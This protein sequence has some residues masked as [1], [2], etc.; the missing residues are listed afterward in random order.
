MK[1]GSRC[2][3]LGL[4]TLVL[5]GSDGST[6]FADPPTQEIKKTTDRVIEILQD[7]MSSGDTKKAER[8]EMLRQAL[9][10]RFDFREMARRSLGS[11][12]KSQNGRQEEF[13]SAFTNFVENAYVIKI[14][15]FKDEKII[16][17]RERVEK[18]FAE[19]DTKIVPSKGDPFS[20]N[21]K[22][23]LVREQWKVYD[24]VVENISLVNNYRSQFNRILTNTS[25]DEL[26]RKLREKGSERGS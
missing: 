1:S 14:E 23:H 16:Y 3:R 11:H 7:P 10:P 15:S 25:F 19:V 4:I 26:L 17:G 6:A 5:W 20:I 21:Y 18:D 13:V 12:W 22:L 24:M 2:L 9:L 8:R